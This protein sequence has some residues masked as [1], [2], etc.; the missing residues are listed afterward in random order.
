MLWLKLS[1]SSW[2]T[3]CAHLR[4][5]SMSGKEARRHGG[6]MAIRKKSKIASAALAVGLCAAGFGIGAENVVT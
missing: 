1:A 4:K 6:N 2:L 3:N 5:E